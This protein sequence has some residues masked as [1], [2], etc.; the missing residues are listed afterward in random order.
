MKRWLVLPVLFLSVVFLNSCLDLEDDHAEEERIRIEAYLKLSPLQY[1]K[2]QS[3]IYYCKI[4][5]GQGESPVPGDFIK[6]SYVGRLFNKNVF[7]TN[8]KD[9]AIHYKIYRQG[10]NYSPFYTP[11]LNAEYPN[12]RLILGVEE[13][14]FLMK[15][16]E[17]ATF[18]IPYHL[19]YGGVSTSNI[20]GYSTLL[21]D[22]KLDK[23][24]PDPA[25][26]EVESI[27]S[28]VAENYPDLLP[29][30]DGI[31]YVDLNE[32]EGD[33]ALEGLTVK[34]NYSAYLLNGYC[35]FTNVMSIAE[36][37]GIYNPTY[38]YSPLEMVVGTSSQM[39]GLSSA[40][41]NMK[42]GGKARAIIPS[43]FAYGT[44]GS[45]VVAPYT[46][47]V[48]EIELVSVGSNTETK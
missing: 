1:E 46:P 6:F 44:T 19:A 15:E 32:G 39:K 43:A 9:T 25:A 29:T 24:I 42:E 10:R 31:Y 7:D 22:I 33:F 35:V 18:I 41:K 21:F 16:G 20:P 40:I 2:Q 17:S 14:I 23:V 34:V 28:Y 11:L 13:A 26:Y 36:S 3:G 4:E 38:T 27:D 48:L 5:E 12:Y 30:S 8:Y 37:N 47:I 45:N